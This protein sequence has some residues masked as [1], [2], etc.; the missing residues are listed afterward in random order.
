MKVFYLAVAQKSGEPE[1]Y[2]SLFSVKKTAEDMLNILQKK[3]YI[4]RR[5]VEI[6]KNTLMEVQL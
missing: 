5:I 2:A 6:E 1:V 4:N 3:G